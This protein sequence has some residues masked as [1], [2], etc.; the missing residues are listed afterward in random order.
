MPKLLRSVGTARSRAWSSALARYAIEARPENLAV[1]TGWEDKW[2]PAAER[3]ANGLP[4][5]F[6]GAPAPPGTGAAAAA[7][8]AVT[9]RFRAG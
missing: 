4:E 2:R 3:A 1:I 6:A 8:T 9:Q 7:V 5:T